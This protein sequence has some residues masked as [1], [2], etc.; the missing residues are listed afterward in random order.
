MKSIHVNSFIILS[1][2]LFMVSPIYGQ[3]SYKLSGAQKLTVSGTSTIHD[4]QMVA[5]DNTS[6]TAE[7]TIEKG[8]L[9]SIQSM[10]I[11]LPV[12]SLKSGK[13]GMDNNA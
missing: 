5:N 10:T 9:V 4:W 6:G 12:K 2:L 13:G 11:N 1:V 3:Q 7:L 8:N